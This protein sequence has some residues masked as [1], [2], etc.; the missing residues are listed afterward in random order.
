MAVPEILREYVNGK[1]E[2]KWGAFWA[3]IININ[4]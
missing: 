3:A 1:N 4:N 2:L